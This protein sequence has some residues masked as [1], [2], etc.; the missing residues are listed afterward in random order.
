[1]D[2]IY[3]P[4]NRAGFEIGNYVIIKPVEDSEIDK[5]KLKKSIAKPYFYNINYLESIKIKIIEDIMTII[6]K[7]NPENEN[8]IIIG[9]FLDKGFN[10]NDIDI[11]IITNKKLNE[12]NLEKQIETIL[13]IKTHI[14]IFD[15]TSLIKAFSTDPLYQ[16]MLN[17][18][19]SKKRFIFKISKEDKKS[20]INYKILDLN[21]LKSKIMIDN[22][23]VLNGREKY[24]LTRNL[25]AINLFLENKK[26]TKEIIDKKIEKSFT[27][28]DINELKDNLVDKQKFLKKYK[29]IYEETFNK[30]I[31]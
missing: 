1:M 14:I 7:T 22:F 12:I 29:N 2:Q 10:F 13:G 26:I 18:C 15:N 28:K 9:S 4:K 5:N 3:I 24:K 8:I 31:A 30:E 21:L 19:V 17:K 25:I 11:I 23:K 6:N 27:L 16:L 20:K